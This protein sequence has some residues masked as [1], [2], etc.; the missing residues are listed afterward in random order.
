MPCINRPR[1]PVSGFAEQ[2]KFPQ[3]KSALTKTPRV[4]GASSSAMSFY[5]YAYAL[6]VLL[7]VMLLAA[8]VSIRSLSPSSPSTAAAAAAASCCNNAESI[9]AD[10]PPQNV[11]NRI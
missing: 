11:N 5:K 6:A 10:R 8:L 4:H 2:L 9:R 7:S 1:S 3:I